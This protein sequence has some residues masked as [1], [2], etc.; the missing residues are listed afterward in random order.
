V[1]MFL[2]VFKVNIIFSVLFVQWLCISRLDYRYYFK[3][4]VV[5]SLVA[6]PDVFLWQMQPADTLIFLTE[7]LSLNYVIKFVSL[8]IFSSSLYMFFSQICI[9]IL[10]VCNWLS[11]VFRHFN[12]LT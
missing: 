6:H 5:Q 3:F 1:F 11:A 9:F 7:F 2:F 12:L 10:L 8:S 4:F